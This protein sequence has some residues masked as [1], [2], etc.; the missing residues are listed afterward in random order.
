M[1]IFYTRKES[2]QT[3]LYVEKAYSFYL[4]VLIAIASSVFE[5]E[6]TAFTGQNS[7]Y[8]FTGLMLI[9]IFA[10]LFFMTS[11]RQEIS[12]AMQAGKAKASGSRFSLFRPL[13]TEI[14]K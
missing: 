6:M 4:I 9:I 11:M 8:L 3:I 5:K 14:A 7:T 1:K 13:T 12:M 10:R 2:S